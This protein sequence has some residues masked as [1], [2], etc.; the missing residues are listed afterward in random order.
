MIIRRALAKDFRDFYAINLQVDTYH[1]LAVPSRFQTFDGD[2][3]LFMFNRFTDLLANENCIFLVAAKED[4]V[5]GYLIALKRPA[6]QYPIL[7]PSKYILIDNMGVH[8]NAQRQGIGSL[9]LQRIEV[10]AIEAGYSELELNVYCFNENAQKLYAKNDFEP[11]TKRMRK[12][13]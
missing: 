10:E 9:L 3:E 8:E 12:L 4:S 6:P 5:L 11:L 1:H 13:L 2:Y 7:K